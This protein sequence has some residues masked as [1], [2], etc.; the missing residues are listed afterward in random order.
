M[1]QNKSLLGLTVLI[2]ILIFSGCNLFLDETEITATMIEEVEEL[3]GLL[4]AFDAALALVEPAEPGVRTIATD[5]PF[6]GS[7]S[8]DKMPAA[9][10]LFLEG[11]GTNTVRYPQT[12]DT[13]MTRFYN[14]EGNEAVLE[15]SKV[16][17]TPELYQVSLKIYPVLSSAVDY[18]H[19]EY[20][21]GPDSWEIVDS[22]GDVAPLAYQTNS[23]YY[24]DGRIQVHEVVWNRYSDT[25]TQYYYDTLFS[26]ANHD[27]PDTA[28][29]DYP[30]TNDPDQ[31]SDAEPATETAVA[32]D[33]K[34]S[35][36]VVSSI[37]DT[38]EE[39]VEF[40]TE[41]DGVR[42]AVSYSTRDDSQGSWYTSVENTVRRYS[43]DA[44]GNKTVRSKTVT[45]MTFSG[46]TWEA[47][48]TE[49][50]DVAISGSDVTFT[51]TT[52]SDQ[53]DSTYSTVMSLTK[54]VS[55]QFA[56]SMTYTVDET[57]DSYSVVMDSSEGLEIENSAGKKSQF[58]ANQ[59]AKNR[60]VLVKLSKGG[61]FAGELKGKELRGQYTAGKKS[62]DVVASP[63]YISISSG[64]NKKVK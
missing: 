13:Y 17:E 14:T 28:I 61:S 42:S 62:A 12:E 55:G 48:T 8:F 57:T 51:S 39:I 29:F 25:G 36:Y 41:V 23:T 47:T 52:L 33:G 24:F 50:V 5:T 18:V 7:E 11:D 21:V 4:P 32:G 49:E 16:S 45:T 15:L 19:E 9:L 44:N 64:K 35:S 26:T 20:Y 34:Y 31:L 56:G 30:S 58:A 6:D 38:G 60:Q 37:E 3:Q 1:K 59:R 54:N 53:G 40:Y 2:P 27:D 43:E 22:I 46:Y 63:G 10:Y